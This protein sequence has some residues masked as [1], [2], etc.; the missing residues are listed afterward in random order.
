MS[1]TIFGAVFLLLVFIGTITIAYAIMF[2]LLVP[3]RKYDY[4]IVLPSNTCSE[5][6]T[7]AV[8]AA[9]T[10][11]DLLGD[12]GYGKVIVVDMGMTQAQKLSC[13]NICRQTNGIYLIESEQMKELF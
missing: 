6:L 8:Y 7:K 4:Y 10:K 13:L 11:I 12:S 9:K 1:E 5:E 3:K 2:K